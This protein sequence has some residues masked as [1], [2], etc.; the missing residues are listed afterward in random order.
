MIFQPIR[1]LKK[2]PIF[3]H[4][5]VALTLV[6]LLAVSVISFVLTASTA[7]AAV[8][9]N[10]QLNYQ[11][12]LLNAAGAVVPDGTYNLEFKLYTGG[13]GCVSAGVSPCGGT[14]VWT[15]DWVYGTGAPDNR[16]IVRNGYFS[17]SLGSITSMASVDFNNDT[18]WLSANVGNTTTAATFSVAAGDGEMLPFKRLASSPYAMNAGKLGGIAAANY[19]QFASGNLQAD[20]STNASIQINKTGATGS[21]LDLQKG[22]AGVVLVNNSG[23]TLLRPTVDSQTALQVQK[24]GTTTTIFTVDST[25]SR[26]GIGTGAPAYAVDAVGSVNASIDLKVA[27]T[28]VCTVTGCTTSS[29]SAIQNNTALQTSANFNI[30]AATSGVAGTIGGIIRGAAGGQTADLLQIQSTAGGTLA[31]FKSTGALDLSGVGSGVTAL[32]LNGGNTIDGSGAGVRFSGEVRALGGFNL[33]KGTFHPVGGNY[34]ALPVAGAT[35]QTADLQQFQNSNGNVLT[36]FDANGA[37]TTYGTNTNLLGLATPVITLTTGTSGTTFYYVVTATNAAGETVASNAI[38]TTTNTVTLGWTLIPGATGYKVYRN[39][40]NSFTTG[41]LLAST[42]TNGSTITFTD[43]GAATAGTFPSSSVT[44]NKLVVQAWANQGSNLFEVKNSSGSNSLTVSSTGDLT[45]NGADLSARNLISTA[46][47]VNGNVGSA[48]TISTNGAPFNGSSVDLV[49]K[50][51]ALQTGDLLQ[52]QDNN[53]LINGPPFVEIVAAEPVLPFTNNAVLI[54][55]RA[56]KSENASVSPPLLSTVNTFEP[57][58]FL[59]SNKLLPWLA[60]ACTTNLFP[61]TELSGNVPVVA[62]PPSVKL[63]MLPFVMVLAS[64]VP[65]IKLL[66]VLRYTL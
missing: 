33:Q 65:A 53:G 16:I 11:G 15:E 38:G 58:E 66:L 24:A 25:N 8:G 6:G 43:S 32:T 57:L 3:T 45:I 30:Q 5:T 44:G 9:I 34:I 49:L 50:G 4:L 60:Q 31:A 55:L 10:P 54:K 64:N 39:T 35:G 19:V 36:K 14:N 17:V 42:I 2:T 59:T 62:A 52:F 63:T 26:I 21:I 61:V 48:A 18:L 1:R 13:T 46:L 27:G 29:T 28:T 20:A 37:L 7:S 23:Q 56:L 41:T 51:A 22:G 47:F 12:R 40:T